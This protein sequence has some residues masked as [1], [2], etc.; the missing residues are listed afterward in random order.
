MFEKMLIS[1]VDLTN[2][3]VLYIIIRNKNDAV[4]NIILQIELK[5]GTMIYIYV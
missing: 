1:D 3:G 5:V 4:F 2:T